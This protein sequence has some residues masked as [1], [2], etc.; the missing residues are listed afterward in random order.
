MLL[1]KPT[2]LRVLPS[3]RKVSVEDYLR[4]EEKS[5]CKHEYHNGIIKKIAGGT[6]NHDNLAGKIIT[7]INVF[8]EENDLSYLVNGS[9][10]KIRIEHFNKFVYPDAVVVCENRDYNGDGATKLLNHALPQRLC[11]DCK[12]RQIAL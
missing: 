8:L 11:S 12:N 10:T 3:A 4:A 6:F 2:R 5:L 7:L 9:D 1:A